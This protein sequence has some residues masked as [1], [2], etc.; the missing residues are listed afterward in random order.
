MASGDVQGVYYRDTCRS[1]AVRHG[2]RGW[3]RN[4]PDGSVE[5]LFEGEPEA[6][7]RLVE[8]AHEGSPAAFVDDVQ[9]FEQEPGGLEGFEVRP[10][11]TPRR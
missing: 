8:W 5:A 4:L 6:V 7:E 3:V 11:P 1:T 2:V 9:I 10:T